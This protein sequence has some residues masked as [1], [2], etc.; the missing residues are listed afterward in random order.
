[1]GQKGIASVCLYIQQ[2]SIILVS[3]HSSFDITLYI[4]STFLFDLNQGK[5]AYKNPSAIWISLAFR[6]LQI[7][8][9]KFLINEN[10]LE[11]AIISST[12][13]HD[14]CGIDFE[15]EKGSDSSS[16]ALLELLFNK[17]A[18]ASCF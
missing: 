1:M 13:P 7:Q 9:F 12:S 4:L 10:S 3:R 5:R 8:T 15:N 14:L 16:M 11:L 18:I 2:E 17:V 6:I